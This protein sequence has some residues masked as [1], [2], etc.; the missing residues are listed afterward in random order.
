MASPLSAYFPGTTRGTARETRTSSGRP[1]FTAGSPRRERRAGRQ[2]APRGKPPAAAQ[3]VPDPQ[4]RRA[5]W[6]CLP[7]RDVSIPN[8][9]RVCPNAAI[10]STSPAGCGPVEGRRAGRPSPPCID[11]LRDTQG[12][13]R[14]A[15]LEPSRRKSA[16]ADFA[17]A[18]GS[19]TGTA[20][21]STALASA[22]RSLRAAPHGAGLAGRWISTPRA[23]CPPPRRGRRR[24][25]CLPGMRRRAGSPHPAR[26]GPASGV[27]PPPPPL[28]RPW[29]H[30][31]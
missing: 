24:P 14:A 12:V 7:H 16:A 23:A 13:L 8:R 25:R 22:S 10:P 9:R 21:A 17:A 19:R 26:C 1:R 3:A 28:R 31:R 6:Q 2:G 29:R 4:G 15:T 30:R 18:T 5:S 11:L 27:R 20:G